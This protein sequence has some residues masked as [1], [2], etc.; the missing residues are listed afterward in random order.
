M[1]SADNQLSSQ[2]R[3]ERYAQRVELNIRTWITPVMKLLRMK[4]VNEMFFTDILLR[5]L[6]FGRMIGTINNE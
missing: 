6:S 3:T 1:I 5:A 4:L 2:I